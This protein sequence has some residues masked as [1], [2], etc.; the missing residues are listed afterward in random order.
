[1]DFPFEAG[2]REEK[3]ASTR[4]QRGRTTLD[5]HLQ[6]VYSVESF[7][8]VTVPA[9]NFKAYKIK[10]ALTEMLNGKNHSAVRYLW[11]APELGYYVKRQQDLNASD[12]K[13]YWQTARITSWCR[14]PV[15]ESF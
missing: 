3:A 4:Q 9:G 1:M 5:F 6:N 2:E 15:R 10:Q 12:D 11:Y 13:S 7:E 14:S 8:D